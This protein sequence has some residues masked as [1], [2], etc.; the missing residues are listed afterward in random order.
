VQR[1]AARESRDRLETV[2]VEDG[3]V[4]VAPF[5]HHE[6]VE[7]VRAELRAVAEI[8]G[9][10]VLD[11]RG[12]DLGHPPVGRDRGCCINVVDERRGVGRRKLVAERRHLRGHPPLGDGVER[13]RPA[14]ALEVRGQKRGTHAAEAVRAMAARAVLGVQLGRIARRMDRQSDRAENERGHAVQELDDFRAALHRSTP[15]LH[16]RRSAVSTTVFQRE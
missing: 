5:D 9:L 3:H 11:A 6:Q 4:V 14:Q 8:A 15:S 16:A 12:G 7:R 10:G 1:V 13:G 2:A